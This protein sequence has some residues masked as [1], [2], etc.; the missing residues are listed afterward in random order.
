M[1]LFIV[2]LVFV[3]CVGAQNNDLETMSWNE[4][5]PLKFSD[6]RD[7][8]NPNTDAAAL[9][10]SGISFGFSINREGS[11]VTD[12][13]TDVDCV[14]YPTKSWFK[15]EHTTQHILKHEQLHFD[16]TELHA[17]MFRQKISQLR[18]SSQIKSQLNQL[19]KAISKAS[20]QMQQLYDE[21]TRHSI[22]RPKQAA[23]QAYVAAELKK[24][25][26]F[27]TK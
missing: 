6:F 25:N 24:L 2:F 20:S 23:W 8:P 5:R 11:R 19:Y 17:R 21:E 22:D 16:I 13:S 18:P 7:R 27:K 4:N 1:R 14:F 9:T 15:K 3:S 12:F 10:A 26:A